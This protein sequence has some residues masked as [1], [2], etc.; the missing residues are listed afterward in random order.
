MRFVNDPLTVRTL[1]LGLVAATSIPGVGMAVRWAFA[2]IDGEATDPA[3][4]VV[5]S[6]DADADAEPA[7]AA[8]AREVFPVAAFSAELWRSGD[9]SGGGEPAGTRRVP[10]STPRP[11]VPAPDPAARARVLR[12]DWRLLAITRIGDGYVAA[13]YD[14]AEDRVRML[15]TAL[16]LEVVAGSVRVESVDAVGVRLVA[17]EDRWDL[18][19]DADSGSTEP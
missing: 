19:L 8:A 15:R 9:A 7:Q 11:P 4:A 18:R 10:A 6:T 16:E 12:P 3:G 17:G 14:V 13:V 5:V 1:A 2:P